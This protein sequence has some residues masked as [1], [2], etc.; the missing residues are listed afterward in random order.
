[1]TPLAA[2]SKFSSKISKY[3]IISLMIYEI[4]Q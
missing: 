4:C 1:M 3:L 2:M